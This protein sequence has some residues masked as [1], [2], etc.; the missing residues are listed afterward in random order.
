MALSALILGVSIAMAFLLSGLALASRLVRRSILSVLGILYTIPSLALFVLLQPVF[1]VTR[2]T[3][4]IIALVGY[5]QLLLVRNVL[6]GLEGVPDDILE[7]ARGTGYGPARLL[8][9]VRLPMALPAI[10]AG[11]RLT[12][13]STVSLL[14]VGGLINQGGL[15][16]LIL[17][18]Q[19]RDIRAQVLTGVVLIVALALIADL[20]LLLFQRGHTRGCGPGAEEA[21]MG[22]FSSALKYLGDGSHW[23]GA[24]GILALARSHL[25]FTV[26]AVAIATVI[27]LGLGVLLG[28]VGRGGGAVTAL[29]N[30]TRAVPVLGLLA[31][32]AT[33]GSSG[34]SGTSAVIALAV[35][36]IA[37]ILTNTYAGMSSVDRETREAATGLGMSGRQVLVGVELPLALPLIAAGLRTAVLQVFAT[38]TIASFVGSNT[39]GN[40]I[41]DGQATSS[42]DQVLA[43]AICIA[44]IAVALDLL[45]ATLQAL[46]TPGTGNL[47]H[48]SARAAS[49]KCSG[50]ASGAVVSETDVAELVPSP[51]TNGPEP[52]GHARRTAFAGHRRRGSREALR[53]GIGRARPDR[54]ARAH[55]L[56][57]QQFVELFGKQRR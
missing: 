41:N 21:V 17:D 52:V 5:A 35:F 54:S 18:G 40:L 23:T 28:H 13:V 37:P 38:A 34:V 39:L 56:W 46:V 3:P 26:V 42:Y 14:S 7:A 49:E 24:D 15:G 16:Q 47:L 20:L 1:G 19:Q 22:L 51:A 44:V 32:L 33:N 12:A 11:I 27:G 48:V 36:A 29:A 57:R 55:R 6:V 50:P 2:A 43:G 8:L 25:L 53:T 4:V 10:M 31:L 9:T 45:L 30:L